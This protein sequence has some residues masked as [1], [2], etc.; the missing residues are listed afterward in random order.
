[1]KKRL[2]LLVV[3]GLTLLGLASRSVAQADMEKVQLSAGSFR[4]VDLP[5]DMKTIKVADQKIVKA[6]MISKKSLRLTGLEAGITDVQIAGDSGLTR[7]YNIV[8]TDNLREEVNALRRDLD[9]VPEVEVTLNQDR[10][11]LKGEISR[12]ANWETFQKVI[13]SMEKKPLNLVTFRPAPEAVLT[14]KDMLDKLGYKIYTDNTTATAPGTLSL[15]LLGEGLHISGSVYSPA[16]VERIRNVLGAQKWLT[17]EKNKT[18]S[19]SLPVIWDVEVLPQLIEVG[20]VFVG[21]SDMKSQEIG[22]NLAKEGLLS[23]N[24]LAQ[25]VGGKDI[26]D[27]YSGAYVVRSNLQGTLNFMANDGN[28]RFHQAGHLTFKSNDTPDWRLLKSGGTLKVKVGNDNSADLKDIEYGLIIKVKGGLRTA[29]AADLELEVEL[30]V[31][32]ANALGDYNLKQNK[33]S[34]SVQ[35]KLGETLVLGG[36]KALLEGTTG[37]SGVPLLRSI[38]GIQWFFSEQ[39]TTRED[40]QVLVLVSP[41]F[42]GQKALILPAVSAQTADTL[43]Q[44]EKPTKERAKEKRGGRRWFFF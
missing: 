43:E 34:T 10:I 13:A 7:T 6:E 28:A 38:P 30:S 41:Q 29:D 42:T 26:T 11:V 32:E 17:L 40:A 19:G 33:I 18:D 35:C 1:M 25:M 2:W 36:M 16:H 24:T 37:P 14:V 21:I 27:R 12:P 9:M 23:V 5:F 15:R 8:V 3:F 20:V 39:G 4:N 22:V 44:S 31:P